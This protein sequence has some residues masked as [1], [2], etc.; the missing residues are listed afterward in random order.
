MPAESSSL[1]AFFGNGFWRMPT[2]TMSF[3]AT[4]ALTS[5]RTS[6]PWRAILSRTAGWIFPSS[7]I[8]RA[9]L[10][11]RHAF[12]D[13]QIALHRVA[14][15]VLERFLVGRGV[16]AGDGRL[17]ARELDHHDALVHAAFV[18]LRRVAAYQIFSARGLDRRHRKLGVRLERVLVLDRVIRH[19]PISFG[20]RSSFRQLVG[21]FVIPS[22]SSRASHPEV[23]SRGVIPSCHPERSEGSLPAHCDTGGPSLSSP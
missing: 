19:H 18:G 11:L 5:A 20:H 1:R 9:M 3:A 2:T 12:E 6:A 21:L 22:I 15:E 4:A 16:V 7:R 23:S 13:A 14:R 17:Q 10:A 8:S